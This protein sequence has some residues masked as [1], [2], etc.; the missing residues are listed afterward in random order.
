MPNNSSGH[1]HNNGPD[2]HIPN[3][4]CSSTNLA[5]SP[6]FDTTQQF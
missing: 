4:D 3:N 1:T 5:T 6:Y 2:W